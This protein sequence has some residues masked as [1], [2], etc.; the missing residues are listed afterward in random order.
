MK[1][2][3]RLVYQVA[4]WLLS[5]L[6]LSLLAGISFL[7]RLLS[8]D[9]AS[10]RRW[11]WGPIPI[12]SNAFW[13]RA[14]RLAGHSSET[15]T[16]GF[17]DVIHARQDWDVLLEEK[18][19]FVPIIQFRYYLAFIESLF[20]YD[21]FVIPFSGYYLGLTPL[22]RFESFFFRLAKKKTIVLPYGGDSYVYRNIRSTNLIHGLMM[23]Y[24][25]A[26]QGQ[27]R[28]FN[29]VIYWCRN[30]DVVIPGIMGPDGFGRW[31]VLTPS[32]V[33]IDLDE[34]KV[35]QRSSRANG[36]LDSVYIVHTPNHR[37]FKG[38]EFIIESVKQLREEGLKVELILIEKKQ[39][40]EVRRILGE[41]AD[42]LV[43]QIIC[44]GHGLSALEGMASGLPTISNL[45]DDTYI[46]P[47]R[48]W[49]FFN[50][51]PLI[52]A[53]PETLTDVL[54]K[55]VT[56]PE[57]RHQLGRAGRQ[58]V[59]KYHGLDSAQYLFGEVVEY[60]YGGRESL[61]NLYHPLLSDYS[62]RKPKVEHPLVYNRITD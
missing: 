42:I 37:G 16:E 44:T 29:K 13:S 46:L 54:R 15:F 47:F 28:I 35:S 26:S 1:A 5:P 34:W 52:S 17:F 45:E 25:K 7:I 43:E 6:Y 4:V 3:K 27:D 31:D 61:I 14:I 49:S 2:M 59:E 23:S 19:R 50:E 62:K 53:S 39:N 22:W 30:G 48:R 24:P 41:D 33:V 9:G 58:Y 57:L 8:A 38:T 20:K 18:Y 40:S 32:T 21:I 12:V 36:V 11:V 51:C 10:K 60:L 55:L 56:R